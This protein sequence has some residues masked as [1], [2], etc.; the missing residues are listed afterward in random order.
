MEPLAGF[1]LDVSRTQTLDV[2]LMR[3][4]S[5]TRD[6]AAATTTSIAPAPLAPVASDDAGP[7]AGAITDAKR[8]PIGRRSGQQVA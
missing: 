6:G 7:T 1:Q 3:M 5:W 2:L 8:L 4:R